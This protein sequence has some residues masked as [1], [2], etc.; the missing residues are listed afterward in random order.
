[1]KKACFRVDYARKQAFLFATMKPGDDQLSACEAVKLV[2][3]LYVGLNGVPLTM[4]P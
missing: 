1:M 3:A 4:M 2:N